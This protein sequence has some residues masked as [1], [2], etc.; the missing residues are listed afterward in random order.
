VEEAALRLAVEAEPRLLLAAEPPE[1][2]PQQPLTLAMAQEAKYCLFLLC[3]LA[4]LA[5]QVRRSRLL[6]CLGSWRGGGGGGGA[7]LQ[8]WPDDALP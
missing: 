1:A 3:G 4:R 2:S 6:H 8:P 5:G 7:R